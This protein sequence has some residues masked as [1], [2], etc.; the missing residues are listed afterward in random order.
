MQKTTSFKTLILVQA[1]MTST[2]LPGKVLKEVLGKPLLS[3]LIERLKCVGQADALVIATTINPLDE[4]IVHLCE[5]ENVPYFRGS[6][7]DVL[8]RYCE[9]AKL[10]K[11]GTVVRVT[12]D[13]PLIDPEVIDEVIM[14]YRKQ[15]VDY[16][17]NALTR[18]YP[19]GMDTEVFSF[20]AL[21]EAAEEATLSSEREHVTPFIYQHPERFKLA[22][23]SYVTNQ[24]HHRW[25]V[26]TKEDFQLISKLLEALY[27]T[28]PHFTLKDLLELIK[29]HPEWSSINQHTRKITGN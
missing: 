16:A 25:T 14:F 9:A 10:H 24:S 12:S 21:E 8:S 4:A 17:S 15:S 23:L 2:R 1:R 19:R 5:K 28:H 6:E 22:N 20:K 11:A 27:P 26:D 3:Y 7:E 18:T 29:K 13:C